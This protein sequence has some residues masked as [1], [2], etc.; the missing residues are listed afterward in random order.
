MYHPIGV[1]V[2]RPS[3]ILEYCCGVVFF[4]FFKY[5]LLVCSCG[6]RQSW[7]NQLLQLIAERA[8]FLYGSEHR[9]R[10]GG[11]IISQVTDAVPRHSLVRLNTSNE[12]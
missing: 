2:K 9:E 5:S 8:V 3:D 6:V 12:K 1:P 11:R 10:P 7:L 4:I